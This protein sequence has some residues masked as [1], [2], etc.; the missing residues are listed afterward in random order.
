MPQPRDAAYNARVDT[1]AQEVGERFRRAFEDK[2]NRDGTTT[3][4]IARA[5][6]LNP[7]GGIRDWASGK[8]L[9]PRR[10]W[11]PLARELGLPVSYFMGQD[12][13][14]GLL[15]A[16]EVLV[17]ELRDRFDSVEELLGVYLDGD[18]QPVDPDAARV[19]GRA[20]GR[21]PRADRRRASSPQRKG[22]A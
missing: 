7:E 12:E 10:H 20:L 14:L 5:L 15:E 4:E 1:E 9:P 17:N 16:T 6:D 19:L 11:V 21:R 22:T 8:R 13:A 18:P 3:A 2:R